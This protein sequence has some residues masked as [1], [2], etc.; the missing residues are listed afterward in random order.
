VGAHWAG[1]HFL[2]L[3]LALDLLEDLELRKAAKSVDI[4]LVL[5]KMQLH[6]LPNLRTLRIQR[7]SAAREDAALL[8]DLLESRWNVPETVS[9][10]VQ[11]TAFRLDS[12]LAEVPDL[13]S[14]AVLRLARLRKEGMDLQIRSSFYLWFPMW[15]DLNILYVAAQVP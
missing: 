9:L 5:L 4:G 15:V 11:M 10:P 7:A 1:D 3:F 6:L 13:D 12:P 8:A 14:S 2:R